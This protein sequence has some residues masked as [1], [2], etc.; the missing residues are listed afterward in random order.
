[1]T[2]TGDW[3]DQPLAI[4]LSGGGYRAA[5][6]HLGTLHYFDRAGLLGNLGALSTI[7]GGSLLGAMYLLSLAD[8]EAFDSF[9]ERAYARLLGTDQIADSLELLDAPSSAPSR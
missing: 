8:E 9:F 3:L 6:F 5:A 4:C 1:M 7:S 2:D